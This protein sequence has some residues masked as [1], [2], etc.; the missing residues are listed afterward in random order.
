[1]ERLI[2]PQ[3]AWRDRT[4]L[5]ALCDALGAAQGDARFVGG[6]V[7]DTLLELPVQ[8]IDIQINA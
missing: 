3:A 7:R 6:A 5:A 1:M 4:G 8:D 2:L